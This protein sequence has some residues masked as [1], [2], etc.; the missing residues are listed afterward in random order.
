M[1][2]FH[3]QLITD[4]SAAPDLQTAIAQALAGGIDSVQVREKSL[5]AQSLFELAMRAGALCHAAEAA[6]F[7]NDRIDVALAAGADGAHLGGRSLPVRAA[8]PLLTGGRLLGLSVHS[9]AE[10]QD[11][12]EA[13]ADYVTFGSL[14]PTRSH[15]GQAPAGLAELARVVEGVN[16]PV[17]AIGGITPANASEV[18]ATGCAGIAL[19]SAIL[20]APSPQATAAE[21]RA[22]LDQSPHRPRFTFPR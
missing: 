13:G 17:L 11:A 12:A 6:L 21:L 22:V 9:L 7:V 18:L 10:A 8:R 20:I 1:A 3:L 4:S 14:F 15:P 16:L 5:P 2:R 19:I